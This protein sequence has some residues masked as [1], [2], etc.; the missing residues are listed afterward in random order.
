V[1]RVQHGV[2][3]VRAGDGQDLRVDAADGFVIG[4]EAAGDDDL[5][6]SGDG[7]ADSFQGLGAGAHEEAAGVHDHRVGG[8][9]GR[10]DLVSLGAQAGDDPLGVDQRLGAAEADEADLRSARGRRVAWRRPRVAAADAAGTGMGP[11]IRVAP[12]PP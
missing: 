7:L 10:G 6:V 12:A 4:A 8:L 11:Y 1:D 2:V 3:L 9:V 5:A